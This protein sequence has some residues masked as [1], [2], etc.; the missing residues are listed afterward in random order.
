MKSA[1]SIVV[2]ILCF[3]IVGGVWQIIQM[4]VELLTGGFKGQRDEAM[5]WLLFR[6]L[7][8]AIAIGLAA[9][10]AALAGI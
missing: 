10:I 8:V 2:A 9:G 7:G 1:A 5:K 3:A 6:I 4:C